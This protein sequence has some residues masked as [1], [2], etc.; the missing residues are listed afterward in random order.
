MTDSLIVMQ[1]RETFVVCTADRLCVAGVEHDLH[2]FEPANRCCAHP[3]CVLLCICVVL[4]DLL[5]AVHEEV[6]AKGQ[7]ES[8]QSLSISQS[9]EILSLNGPISPRRHREPIDIEYFFP[10]SLFAFWYKVEMDSSQIGRLVKS[11]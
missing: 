2:A 10:H 5:W 3:T 1:K 7:L 6:K 4:T 9:H 8:Y 11:G